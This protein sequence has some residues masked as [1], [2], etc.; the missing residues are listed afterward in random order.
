MARSPGSYQSLMD[1]WCTILVIHP[2]PLALLTHWEE[3]KASLRYFAS[4]LKKYYDSHIF[5]YADYNYG[6]ACNLQA[7]SSQSNRLELRFR[8]E[9]PYSHPAFGEC[10]PTNAL[11]LKISKK[12]IPDDDGAKA[13]N[14]M[15]GMEHVMQET[16]VESEHGAADKVDEKE[17]VCADIVAHVPEAYF[18]EGQNLE[19]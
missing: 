12:K 7:R 6:H 8:P 10:R 13:S 16:P 15:C 5:F 2:Q 18:F 14:N 19:T 9:D 4:F 17:S 3:L 11:L 1:F